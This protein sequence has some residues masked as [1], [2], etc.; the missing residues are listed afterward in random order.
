[1]KSSRPQQEKRQRVVPF[2]IS[3]LFLHMLLVIGF[4]IHHSFFKDEGVAKVKVEP[5]VQFL[6]M[7]DINTGRLVEQDEKEAPSKEKPKDAKFL[8]AHD[9]V[10][11][12]ETRA[13]HRGDFQN[14]NSS[15]SPQAAANQAAPA[16]RPQ[17]AQPAQ[18]AEPNTAANM[19]TFANGD[20]SVP[21]KPKKEVQ[22]A[23]S[24]VADLRP[25]TMQNM[26]ESAMASVSQTQ[27]YLKDVAAGA[28]T[29]LNTREF[30]YYSYFNRIKRQLHQRWEP[31]IHEKVKKIVK[32]GQQRE[33]A[34]T[35]I[36]VTNVVFT[37]DD[38]GVITRIQV[39]TTSGLEDLDDAA[40]EALKA[41]GQFPHPPKDLI[42]EGFVKI[43]W[44]FILES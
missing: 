43:Q 42:I 41:V 35:E 15:E 26:S 29:Q 24:T 36:K 31:I 9:K 37:L 44:S 23:A 21:M 4:T 38:R 39:G 32:Q 19:K 33:L 28:E 6:D 22:K 20:I 5:S 14:K 11:K 10:V 16:Q 18:P 12:K 27:D 17:V 25:N 30:I 34:S 40:I 13:V 1:M 8:S 2:L 7:K 3:S